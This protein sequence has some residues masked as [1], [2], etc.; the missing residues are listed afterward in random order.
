MKTIMTTP[1]TVRLIALCGVA[2]TISSSLWGQS[3]LSPDLQSRNSDQNVDVIVQYRDTPTSETHQR[4]V[5]LR[6]VMKH[7]L[8]L[9]KARH[10]NMPA[11]SLADLAND[12]DVEY[13][14]PDRPV[15]AH[16]DQAHATIGANLSSQYSVDGTGIGVAVIDSGIAAHGDLPTPAYYQNFTTDPTN[17]RG[18]TYADDYFGHG[19]HVAGIIAGSGLL[20]GGTLSIYPITG[21]AQGVNLIDLQ[22]LDHNGVGTDSNVILAIQK[23][24]ALKTT[25]NIKVINLSLGRPVAESYTKDPLCQAV[26]QAWKGR[27]RSGGGSRQLRA[28]QSDDHLRLRHHHRAGQRS[29]CHY[30]GRYEHQGHRSPDG[31]CHREL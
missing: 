5:G 8:G 22:V 20:S 30:C 3:K 12:P 18:R 28:R 19:T 23:A 27:H 13:V 4:M 2:I 24:I 9:I 17:D 1:N 21:V 15:M 14:T 10:Y 7:D 16:V 11:S 31:R 25:Y 29:L 6:G 26:E